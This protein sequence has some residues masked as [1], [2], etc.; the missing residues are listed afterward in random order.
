MDQELNKLESFTIEEFQKDFDTLIDRVEKN[1]E[2][3]L[4]RLPDGKGVVM[5]PVADDMKDLFDDVVNKN[6]A[7]EIT[8]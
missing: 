8:D 1:Q 7:P 3:F 2:L 4:I 5:T 6:Y